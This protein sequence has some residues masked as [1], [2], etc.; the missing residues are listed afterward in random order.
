MA[1]TAYPQTEQTQQ[2]PQETQMSPQ[3]E[4]TALKMQIANS[5]RIMAN[6]NSQLQRKIDELSNAVEEL[7]KTNTALQEANKKLTENPSELRLKMTRAE[8]ESKK[9]QDK[10]ASLEKERQALIQ[11]KEAL[12]QFKSNCDALILEIA[13]LKSD[14]AKAREEYEALAKAKDLIARESHGLTLRNKELDEKLLSANKQLA[15]AKSENARFRR[16]IVPVRKLKAK[17]AA[18]YEQLGTAY[19]QLQQYDLAIDAYNK[20]LIYNF[21]NPIVHCNLGLLYEK[22]HARSQR[23]IYHLNKYLE[24]NPD[25][26]DRNEITFIIKRLSEVEDGDIVFYN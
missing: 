15:V 2:Q 19:A 1:A 6:E 21:K 10:A 18:A 25:A 5:K 8:Q 24:F 22:S 16:E 3:E 11:E 4:I 17:L 26:P 14:A 12:A 20:S 7:K 23:A 13:G 9:A